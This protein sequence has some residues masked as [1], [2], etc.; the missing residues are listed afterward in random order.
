MIHTLNNEEL[1]SYLQNLFKEDYYGFLNTTPEPN[2]IRINTLKTTVINFT[3][4]LKSWGQQYKVINF[5]P[6]GLTLQKDDLPLSHTLDYF[7]GNFYYQG[8]SS[9]LPVELLDIKPGEIVLDMAA[10]P[11]SKSCQILNKLNHGGFLVINDF[12]Y[13]RLQA[14]NVNVQRSGAP[15]YYIL[16]TWGEQLGQKY[17]EYFDKVLVDAPCTALGTLAS[18]NEVSKWWSIDKLNKLARSQYALLVSG[19]KALKV[20]GELVYS[21]CSFAPEENE[22][23]IQKALESY[24][25][26]IVDLP[27]NLRDIFSPGVLYYNNEKLSNNMK[28]AIRVYPHKHGFEGFFTIKLRKIDTIKNKRQYNTLQTKNLVKWN[29]PSISTILKEI[30]ETWGIEESIWKNY[31]FNVTKNR[32]WI[33][34]EIDEIPTNN[35]VCSGILLTEKKLSGWK[36]F[37]NG[38]TFFG[39]KIQKRTI[40]LDENSLNN[41]FNKGELTINE[42]EDGYYVLTRKQ[43]PF[44]SVYVEK[45]KMRIKLPHSFNLIL[46]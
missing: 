12:S 21:T 17:Y 5:N 37:N 4:K 41:L 31:K 23:I 24:P 25:V 45:G 36:L 18:S 46:D 44:A 28:N 19:L 13:K 3:K 20:G 22:I 10:A 40:E 11:G 35:F 9:Q 42:F 43:N 27:K 34:G 15:N 32:I 30:S 14:L 8:V 29:D 16:N 26:E 6:T 38:V 7:C 2:S 33:V 1:E 39:S